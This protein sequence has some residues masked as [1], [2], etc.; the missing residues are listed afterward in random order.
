MRQIKNGVSIIIPYHN[1]GRDFIMKT[2]SQIVTTIRLDA[3]EII[4][5]DDNSHTPLELPPTVQV[6]RHQK[7]KGVGAAFDTGVAASNYENLI[8]MGADIRFLDNGWGE[9]MLK[10]IQ[11]HPHA[12]TCTSCVQLSIEHQNILTQRQ[13]KGVRTGAS[14]LLYH[15]HKTNPKKP[16]N[17]RNI[18]EAKWLPLLANRDIDSFDIPCILGA[19][20]GVTKEWYNYCHGFESHRLWGTLEP[21]ISLKSWMFGGSCRVAPRIEVGHIFKKLGTHS[22]PQ[23]VIYFNKMMVATVLFDDYETLIGYIHDLPPKKIAA[24]EYSSIFLGLLNQRILYKQKTIMTAEQV[25]NS[26]NIR[27]HGNFTKKTDHN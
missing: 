20:Y 17:Y 6:I 4:V 26:Q 23:W 14:I 1:E 25:I 16:E 10:E 7:N 15:N 21:Y 11:N 19:F 8:L 12:F 22:T 2:V 18:I 9:A 3:Y 13:R 5:V 27:N 24:K